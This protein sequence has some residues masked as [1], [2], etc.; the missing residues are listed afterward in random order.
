MRCSKCNSLMPGDEKFC[1]EC[2]EPNPETKN[3]QKEENSGSVSQ[4]EANNQTHIFEPIKGMGAIDLIKMSWEVFVQN[5]GIWIGIIIL[6]MVLNVIPILG[7]LLYAVI[8]LMIFPF[9]YLCIVKSLKNKKSNFNDFFDSFQNILSFLGLIIIGG[10]VALI[11][12]GIN[13]GLIFL[14]PEAIR[15]FIGIILF[16][17]NLI[18]ML[19]I[20]P[21]GA[22]SFLGIYAKNLGV[23]SSI[24]E[25]ISLLVKN[26]AQIIPPVLLMMI[27][28]AIS[29]IP[30]GLG[31][32][33]TA[34]MFYILLAELYIKFND[35]L[36]TD[37]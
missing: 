32:L 35:G 14:S 31:L 34:P 5:V 1:P 17:F 4:G 3:N 33:I 19:I 28:T 22:F 21:I 23:I 16:L 8:I 29:M 13:V 37:F 6:G 11:Y 9:A 18:F 30:I 26:I 7:Q 20:S 10:I 15:P 25:S 24:S 2:G 36:R 27:L 12:G